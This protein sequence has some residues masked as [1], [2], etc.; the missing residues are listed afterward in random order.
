MSSSKNRIHR[1][2]LPYRVAA[3]TAAWWIVSFS[4]PATVSGG[5]LALIKRPLATT[6]TSDVCDGIYYVKEG[7]DVSTLRGFRHYFCTGMYSMTLEGPRGEVVTLFG[8]HDFKKE[9]GF[10]VIRKTDDRK[11]WLNDLD[12]IPDG[13]WV[14]RPPTEDSGGVQIFFKPV[15]N[16]SQRISSVKW[17][18][19]WQGHQPE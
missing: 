9:G 4:A 11:V 18:K 14:K 6:T 13:K 10:M 1:R 5:E 7:K 16:F 3:L 12:F 17:G 15:P 19:W 2:G 8:N